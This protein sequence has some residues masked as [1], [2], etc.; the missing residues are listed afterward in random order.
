MHPSSL[1]LP[2]VA[3]GAALLLVLA[4]PTRGFVLTGDILDLTQRDFRVFNNFSHPESNDN[5][6]PDPDFPGY[7]GAVL[8]IWK[9][10]IE[11]QSRLH[12]T[13]GGDP[14]QPGD[15]GSGGANFDPNFQGEALGPGGIDD[16]VHSE[17]SGL[18]GG[19]VSFIDLP[20]SDGWRIRYSAAFCLDD[21]PGVVLSPGCF[22]LQGLAAHEYGHAIGLG[23]SS[24]GGQPTM[25]P[26]I[27][28]N[29]VAARSIEADDIA[30]IQALYGVASPAKPRILGASVAGGMVTITGLNFA[31]VG[32]EVWF[33]QLG[34]GGDGTPVKV[35]GVV[36]GMGGTSIQVSLPPAAGPGDVLVRVPGGGNDRLSDAQPFDPGVA[37]CAP[38]SSYCVTS[39]NSAGPGA[40]IAGGGSAGFAANNLSLNAA[41]CPANQNGIF[42]FGLGQ[43]L[44]PFGD[45]FRCVA[46]VFFRLPIVTTDAAGTALFAFDLTTSPAAG[47]ITPNSTWN[48]Q[49][50]VRDPAAG[51]A[52]FNLSDGLAVMFC[53]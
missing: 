37:G 18:P 11:W 50:W 23:N 10:S 21:G 28:G 52:G 13:G 16:N 2:A 48:F 42:Y 31:A 33:T 19:V 8:A 46:G 30:G 17:I 4:T 15:L 43:T 35:V 40:V 6:T 22:D 12:G 7:T 51:G 25:G 20:S 27:S 29:G 24:A 45:G 36:A 47:V 5:T 38:G 41:G 32:N 1:A 53:P 44:V 14:S 49:F 26:M 9:A 34:A 3:S 39:P